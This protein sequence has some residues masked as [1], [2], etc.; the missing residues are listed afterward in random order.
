MP[1][2][3]LGTCAAVL[4]DTV[5]H[6]EVCFPRKLGVVADSSIAEMEAIVLG[7]ERAI[8][9]GSRKLQLHSDCLHAIGCVLKNGRTKKSRGDLAH[10]GRVAYALLHSENL[11]CWRIDHIPRT[12]NGLADRC[13]DSHVSVFFVN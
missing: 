1:H 5:T 9:Y 6:E 7:I 12:Q 4:R 3:G 10:A 13:V 11:E 2:T 8:W